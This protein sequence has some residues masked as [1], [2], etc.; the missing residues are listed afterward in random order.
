MASSI[1]LNDRTRLNAVRC[2]IF[3]SLV[4]LLFAAA[5]P[6]LGSGDDIL[7]YLGRTIDWYRRAASLA[8]SPVRTQ[9]VVFRDTALQSTR[10]VLQLG[11]QFARAQAALLA[12]DQKSGTSA[13]T[14]PAGS[15]ERNVATAAAAGPRARCWKESTTWNAP[16]PMRK[17]TSRASPRLA[18][19]PP[20]PSKR[21]SR[22]RPALSAS[23]PR[24]SR[25]PARWAT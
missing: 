6:P 25:S 15:R 22:S 18:P 19:P 13:P 9:E 1:V 16:P 12:A 14:A 5:P 11:F 21:L 17:A 2:I 4:S 24:C 8:Q 7:Q 10:R 20:R 23:Y 3:G